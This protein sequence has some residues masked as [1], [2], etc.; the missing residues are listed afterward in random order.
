[1]R[2]NLGSVREIA[3]SICRPVSLGTFAKVRLATK[4]EFVPG[5][6]YQVVRGVMPPKRRHTPANPQ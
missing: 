5:G 1:V 4:Q 3:G 2:L 6:E